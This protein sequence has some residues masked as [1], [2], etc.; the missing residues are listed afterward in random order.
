MSKN[1]GGGSSGKRRPSCGP[2]GGSGSDGGGASVRVAVMVAAETAAALDAKAA[3]LGLSRASVARM[4]IVHYLG[5]HQTE[6]QL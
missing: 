3:A 1:D 6:V 2:E 4:A 5:Q